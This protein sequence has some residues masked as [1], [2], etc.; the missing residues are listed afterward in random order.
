MKKRCREVYVASKRRSIPSE[1]GGFSETRESARSWTWRSA[2]IKKRYG[3][4]IMIES[5]F[6]D[7]TASWVR[8]VIGVNKYVTETSETISF[9]NVEHRVTGKLVAKAKPRLKA[10]CD[11]VSHFY[12]SS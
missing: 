9:E 4:E 6:R 5:L 12:S 2:F 7:G 3:I 1:R 10:C 8:I 11:T